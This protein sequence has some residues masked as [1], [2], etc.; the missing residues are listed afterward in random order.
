MQSAGTK[1]LSAFFSLERGAKKARTLLLAYQVNDGN[2][3]TLG[4]ISGY[5]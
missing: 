4:P 3:K 1:E 2:S 5:R